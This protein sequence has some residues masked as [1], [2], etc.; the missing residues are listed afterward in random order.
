MLH[1]FKGAN[2][3]RDCPIYIGGLSAKMT[4]IYDERSG[5][6][7]RQ[8]PRLQLLPEVDPFVLNG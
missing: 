3:L 2:L 7:R 8:L 1:K 4:E 5:M 6:S